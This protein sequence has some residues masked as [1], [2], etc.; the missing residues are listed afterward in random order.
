[1][2]LLLWRSG[3]GLDF[4]SP[5]MSDTAPLHSLVADMISVAT[6]SVHALRDPTRGG[7]ATTLKEFAISSNIGIVIYEDRIPIK[8]EVQGACE[9][10]GLDPLFVANEGK[11]AASVSSKS[12]EA[13]LKAMRKNKYGKDAAIIGEVVS[14]HPN[15][16]I[17]KT[18]IGGKR[19]VDMLMGEQLPRIC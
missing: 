1:M 3:E 7:L 4:E 8:P 10:L 9:I 6:D 15:T 2:A 16:V 13:V 18:R 11:L 5:I 17:L 14:E 12:A 19:I